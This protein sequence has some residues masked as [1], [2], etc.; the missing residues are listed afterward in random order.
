ME[1]LKEIIIEVMLKNKALKKDLELAEKS[2]NFWY[3]KFVELENKK[4]NE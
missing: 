4:E 2:S 3:K 1:E